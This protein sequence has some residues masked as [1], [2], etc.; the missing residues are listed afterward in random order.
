MSINRVILSGNLTREPDLRATA[1]GTSVLQFSIAVNDRRK[2]QTTGEWEDYPNFFDCTM[3]G[4]RA[5]SLAKILTKGMKVTVEGKLHWSQWERDGQKRS[6]VDVTVDEVE[7]MQRNNTN[8]S[9]PQNAPQQPAQQ[10]YPPQ[11]F[12][13]PYPVNPQ[14]APARAFDLYDEDIPF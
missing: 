1:S 2:N 13:Q 8:G 3:F 9:A 10:A 7:L 11:Q 14:P 12:N 4:S 5:D 6:K